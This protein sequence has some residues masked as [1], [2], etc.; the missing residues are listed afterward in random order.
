M[1]ADEITG[2][3]LP[4]RV[5]CRWKWTVRAGLTVVPMLVLLGGGLVLFLYC[6]A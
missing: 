6:R 3:F 4:S 2:R 5:Y 1:D